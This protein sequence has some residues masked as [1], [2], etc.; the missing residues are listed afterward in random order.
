MLPLSLSLDLMHPLCA[1]GRPHASNE[2][3]EELRSG[4]ELG[5]D[6]V[7]LEFSEALD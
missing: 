1:G 5:S 4:K 6:E 7:E 2:C 3:G